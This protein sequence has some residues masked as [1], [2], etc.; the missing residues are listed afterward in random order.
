MA[1]LRS[2]RIAPCLGA[3][4]VC[5]ACGVSIAPTSEGDAV[6]SIPRTSP[7]DQKETG[8]CWLYATAAWAESL[9]RAAALAGGAP[10]APA[11]F[12]PAYWD[13]WDWYAKITTGAVHG[14]TVAA[15]KD[16]LDSG[17]S[18]GSAVELALARGFVR[19]PDFVGDAAA[20]DA[21][22][23]TAALK[24]LAAS[25]TVGPLSSSTARRD[26]ALVR[27]ELERAFRLGAGVAAA[28]TGVFGEDGS[29]TLTGGAR[30][31]GIVLDAADIVVLHPRADGPA[32]Q[33]SLREAIGDRA[34]GK[35]PDV[36]TGPFA[37]SDELYTAKTPTA[38][39]A[40]FRRIQRALH[41]GAPLPVGWFWA[42]NA[43][44]DDDGAFTAVPTTPASEEDSVDHETLL[45]DY[46]VV[47]VPGYG[48]L[49]AGT[50]ATPEQEE[51][52]L[53]DGARI[54]FFRAKDSYYAYRT[55]K[56][57]RIGFSDLYVDYLT[58]SVRVCPK[59][60]AATSTKCHDT[61]PLEDVTFPPGF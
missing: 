25:L 40:F 60:A 54:V 20:S 47:D 39:R 32:V 52:A 11:R 61:V 27:R 7:R 34:P 56:R 8:N 19:E 45:Y 31:R 28:L 36:R 51:A 16:E 3:V 24:T 9:A 42:D 10:A 50:P 57:A 59:G 4:L 29:A 13:Y 2:L 44:P 14:K 12:A 38:R 1:W 26:G 41:A 37:W 48:R 55:G 49:A 33:G 23:T 5:A 17:G 18:W 35:N 21:N 15:V 30:A 43:D 46:E 53:A 58:G 6:T 22:A